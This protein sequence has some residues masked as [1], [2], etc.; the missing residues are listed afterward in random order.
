[1]DAPSWAVGVFVLV[2][3]RASPRHCHAKVVEDS[4]TARWN[5]TPP[6]RLLAVAP[7]TRRASLNSAEGIREDLHFAREVTGIARANE[8]RLKATVAGIVAARL[9]KPGFAH[10]A[11]RDLL[12][13]HVVRH[14]RSYAEAHDH[15]PCA[16]AAAQSTRDILLQSSESAQ[17]AATLRRQALRTFDCEIGVDAL[18]KREDTII[19]ELAEEVWADLEGRRQG[20]GPQTP[21]QVVL[22]MMPAVKDTHTLLHDL[23]MR[24]YPSEAVELT[25]VVI[26]LVERAI[27]QIA[28]IQWLARTYLS[29][30]E[31][32]DVS[33]A[34]I[35][36]AFASAAQGFLTIPFST[37][38]D[39]D[40]LAELF[41]NNYTS[42]EAF[43]EAFMARP[44]FEEVA[45]RCFEWLSSCHATCGYHRT[46]SFGLLCEPH[47]LTFYLEQFFESA[48]ELFSGEI[49]RDMREAVGPLSTPDFMAQYRTKD[50]EPV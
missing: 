21:E 22:L 39:R 27:Y 19:R 8:N 3:L 26:R 47:L 7:P 44:D 41:V 34:Q 18:R 13:A 23:L 9:T 46:R 33:L 43:V 5:R 35:D 29:V 40:T 14:C 31:R 48:E 17:K 37:D 20:A 45:K 24:L 12:V 36:V 38:F 30:L 28:E 16:K 11:A 49:G 50:S 25:E 32:P 1:M 4:G 15:D 10:R 2:N 42:R 6:P